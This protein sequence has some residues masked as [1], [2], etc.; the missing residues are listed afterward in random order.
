MTLKTRLA[1]I[2][3]QLAEHNQIL[4]ALC[5]EGRLLFARQVEAEKAKGIESPTRKIQRMNADEAVVR[6][7]RRTG[8]KS[9]PWKAK[10]KVA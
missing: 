3:A 8:N 6:A 2:E 10:R 1:L 5:T 4:A 9:W 7:R